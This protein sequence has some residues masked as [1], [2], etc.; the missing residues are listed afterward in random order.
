MSSSPVQLAG[1]T[2]AAWTTTSFI[3]AD[4]QLGL[5][6]N[7][8]GSVEVRVGDGIHSFFSLP[9]VGGGSAGAGN[10]AWDTDGVPYVVT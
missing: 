7:L 8:D 3:L 10:V 5:C 1:G 4:R 2:R 6:R 9:L